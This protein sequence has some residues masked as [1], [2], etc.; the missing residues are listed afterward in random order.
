MTMGY[1]CPYCGEGLPEDETCPCQSYTDEDDEPG[2]RSVISGP[3]TTEVADIRSPV[4]QFLNAHLTAGL[5]GVQRRYRE[6]APALVVPSSA[7]SEANPRTVGT[8]ADWLLRFL[9]H[10]APHLDLAVAGAAR[11]SSVGIRIPRVALDDILHP[12]GLKA[13]LRPSET[14]C[15]FS[16][17]HPG[18]SVEPAILNR[19]CWVLAL[20]TEVFRGGPGVAEFG[21]LSRFR[22]HTASAGELLSMA[23]ETALRQLTQLRQVYEATLLPGLASRHGRW[24][25]GPTFAGSEFMH[26]DADLIAAGLL[27]ELK[28]TAKRPSLGVV[29]LFQVIGYALLD[30]EDEFSVDT[31][32]IFNARSAYLA[33]WSL[34]SLLDELA[35]GSVSL[36]AI[37]A[38]FRDLLVTRSTHAVR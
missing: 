29:D 32:G 13:P 23:S 24:A 14:A 31:V 35:G 17:P 38:Q 25:I 16:G 3:L 37:R 11:C 33:T 12:L 15:A 21:P 6:A 26:A 20:L 18:A 5:R 7:P 8:A 22:G 1:I 4:R 10:P 9:V 27:L 28:T 34:G 2:T 36:D 30:F 19:A